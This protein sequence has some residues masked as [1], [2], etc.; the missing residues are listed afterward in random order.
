MRECGLG[1]GTGVPVIAKVCLQQYSCMGGQMGGGK[2]GRGTPQSCLSWHQPWGGC[3]QEPQSRSVDKEGGR[4]GVAAVQN[5]A[6]FKMVK[7]IL[8]CQ[9]WLF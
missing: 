2:E 7:I 1:A 6:T 9:N 8:V 5:R 4:Q 3:W